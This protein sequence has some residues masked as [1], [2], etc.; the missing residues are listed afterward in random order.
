MHVLQSVYVFTAVCACTAVCVCIVVVYALGAACVEKASSVWTPISQTLARVACTVAHVV[1]VSGC[2]SGSPRP[3][4]P[5][6]CLVFPVSVFF[7]VSVLFLVSQRASGV[8][9]GGPSSHA[10]LGAGDRHFP[11]EVC[12]AAVSCAAPFQCPGARSTHHQCATRMSMLKHATSMQQACIQH[13]SSMHPVRS[14]LAHQGP[15]MHPGDPLDA[16]TLRSPAPTHSWPGPL[17]SGRARWRTQT[18]HQLTHCLVYALVMRVRQLL[19]SPSACA[20][21][22]LSALGCCCNL[23]RLLAVLLRERCEVKEACR[24]R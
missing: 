13:A 21:I 19:L 22:L 16:A 20:A 6:V 14:Q 2:T 17:A 8:V 7:P 15:L 9:H 12:C 5:S 10:V 3:R 18:W 4:P 23:S 24:Q 11:I 1:T